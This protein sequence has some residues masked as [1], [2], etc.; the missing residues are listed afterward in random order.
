MQEGLVK[1]GIKVIGD[2]PWGTHFCQFYQTNQDLLDILVPYFKAGLESNEFCMWVTAQPLAEHEARQAMAQ[3]MPDFSQYVARGQ[4][5]ILPHDRWYLKDG[6]FDLQRVLDGWVDKLNRALAKGYAGMRVTGNTAW[7]ERNGWKDFTEY[8][9]EINNVI[10]KYKMMALCTYWLDKC[11]ASEVIDVVSNHQ[12]ALLKRQG[13]WEIIESTVYKQTKQTEEALRRSKEE[14]EQ[15]FDTI[16]DLVAILDAEHRILRVN[17]AMSD[18]LGVAPDQ[19]VGLKCHE[20]VHGLY[21]PPAFCPHSLTCRDGKEHTA[22]VHEPRLGGDFLVSTTPRLNEQGQLVGSVHVARD[23]TERKKAEEKLKRFNREL[24]A[25]SE[26]NQAMVRAT[27]E[28]A[29]MRDVCRIICDLAGYRMAWVGLAE[30]DS[31]KTVRPVAW[32]G[33]ENEYL[34]NAAITWQDTERGRG[35]TGVA[36]RTGKTDFCQNFETEP[37]AAPWCKAALERGFRSS[38]AIPLTDADRNVFGVFNLYS[39]Q[40]DTFTPDEVRLLEELAGDLSF[41]IMVLRNSEERKQAE[42]DLRETRDYLVNLLNYANAP[43]IVWDPS[44]RITRFN[45]AFERLTGLSANEVMG[46]HLGILFPETEREESMAHIRRAVAGER[47]EVVEI[48]ILSTDG[49]VRTVLWN[50]ATLYAPDGKTAVATMAQGQDIT[51]RK[52][53]EED[54][55][56]TQD[57]L[58]NLLDYANAPIIVWDPS[59]RITQFNHAFERLTGLSANEVLGKELSIL[60]PEDERKESMG[61]IR[62]AVAGEHWEVVEI[63]ILRTD[64]TV[65][66][67]LWNSATLY[68]PDGVTAVATIAQGQDITE[69]KEAEETLRLERDNLFAILEAMKDGVF[70]V[71]EQYTIEYL[72]SELEK[73]FGPLESKKCYQYFHDKEEPCSWCNLGEVMAGKTVRWECSFPKARKTYDLIAAPFTNVDGTVSKLEIFHDITERKRVEELKDEFIGLVS[74][75]MRTPLTVITGGLNTLLTEEANLSRKEKR[76]LLEDAAWESQTLAHILGNL[77]ELSR[78]QANRLF[79]SL[80][81]VDLRVVIRNAIRRVKRQSSIHRFTTSLSRDLPHVHADVMRLERILHNLLE[82]A[83]KYSPDGGNIRVSAKVDS[84]HLVIGVSDQGIGIS[85]QD[86]VKLFAPFQRLED[87]RIERVKGV[88]LG[89]LVCRRLVEAHGGRVWVQSELGKGSTF[90]FTLPLQ[91]NKEEDRNKNEFLR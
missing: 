14:W 28:I 31:A 55:R 68:T 10:G 45:H 29:L 6:V 38:I 15:T 88:G 32:G 90:F 57:Y 59:F 70:I 46:K 63:P 89:L 13:R 82:N 26:C 83:I 72:H 67:V 4:I 1:T 65:R 78:A 16:P 50:S 39:D 75:E 73:D 36:V 87:S 37:R 9:A 2:V 21:H 23:I 77:L 81:P 42:E 24:R 48:P 12:F 17:R 61:H 54:L 22:E 11:G 74:H 91:G 79:L 43:I 27:D 18:R 51:E 85:P 76:Q 30:H 69:R 49:T 3:A 7:L 66:T 47:W 33:T 52:Q 8:E 34:A 25:I 5:E 86:Q 71:N 56:E 84:E 62:R 19:C 40:P 44:F 35:P 53:A 41:G 20:A 60:F 80:E 58:N 64:G